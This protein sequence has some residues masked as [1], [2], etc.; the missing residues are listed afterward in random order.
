MGSASHSPM[1]SARLHPTAELPWQVPL[2]INVLKSLVLMLPCTKGALGWLLG[3]VPMLLQRLPARLSP[4]H[5]SACLGFAL[6]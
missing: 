4:N 2:G 3:E 1:G 6:L 5:F